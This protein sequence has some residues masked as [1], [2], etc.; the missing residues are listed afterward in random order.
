LPRA[1]GKKAAGVDIAFGIL[2]IALL[3]FG[4][5]LFWLF[6]GCLGFVVGLK[7]A[8]IFFGL[9]PAWAVLAAGILLGLIGVLL[10]LFFQKM[11][12]AVGG[13]AAGYMIAAYLALMAGFKAV[14]VIGI[15]GGI[16]GAILLYALFDWALIV[17]SAVTGS[18][19]VVQ[20]LNWG[21]K[22]ENVVYVVLII[23]GILIQSFQ[24]LK[25]TSEPT[26]SPW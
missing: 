15:V 5:K 2:G 1:N 9:Q 25:K 11:A 19:L 16:V 26:Q 14:P 6:V 10:A 18:I 3:T 20:A 8:G 4:R 12:I 22:A 17:L 13:F 21:P 7:A 23:A 24:R